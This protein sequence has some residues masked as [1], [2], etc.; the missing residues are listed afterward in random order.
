MGSSSTGA[1]PAPAQR[2]TA[3]PRGLHEEAD[4]A[5]PQSGVISER[6]RRFAASP[7]GPLD[8]RGQCIVLILKAPVRQ[9]G[10]S[11]G[12]GECR[13]PDAGET[14]RG[15][16]DTHRHAADLQGHCRKDPWRTTV[17]TPTCHP[18]AGSVARSTVPLIPERI[19]M[20]S[21]HGR[22]L[23]TKPGIFVGDGGT[24]PSPRPW[25]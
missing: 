23:L 7:C 2:Q 10:K 21:H 8:G 1:S 11:N 15:Q 18:M 20:T 17:H 14:K 19:L 4:E 24:S 13:Q 12:G 6:A 22:P 3:R 16:R 5:L 9:G 25:T